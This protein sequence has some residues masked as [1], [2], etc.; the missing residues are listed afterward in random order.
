MFELVLLFLFC[1]TSFTVFN[2]LKRRNKIP[3]DSRSIEEKVIAGEDTSE[4]A[5]NF[6]KQL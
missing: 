4:V 6:L 5:K 2:L 3:Q 1:I